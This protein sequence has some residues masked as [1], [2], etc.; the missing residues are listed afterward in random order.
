M[1]LVRHRAKG[2]FTL[3]DVSARLKEEAFAGKS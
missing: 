2:I 3:R 1:G